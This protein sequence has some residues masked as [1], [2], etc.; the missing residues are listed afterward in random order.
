MKT[1][2]VAINNPNFRAGTQTDQ[3]EFVFSFMMEGAKTAALGDMICWLPAIKYIAENYDYV[4]GHLEVPAYFE[5]VARNVM[6]QYPH[7]RVH[8]VLPKRLRNGMPL[9][10]AHRHPINATGMH[11][12]D[13]GFIYYLGMMPPNESSRL[14]CELNLEDVEIWLDI[15]LRGELEKIEDTGAYVVLTPGASALTRAMPPSVF[16]SVVLHLLSKGITPVFL[17]NREMSE[18]V[19]GFDERYDLTKGLDLIGKTT[20]L[21]A[22]KIMR[23]AMFVM[24]I[25]NGL[26]H[27]AGMTDATI[28]YGYTMTGPNQRRIPRRHGHLVELF[29]DK[30]KIP[31]LFCQEHVRFFVDH[32]FTNCIYQENVPACVQALNAESWIA[33]IDQVIGEQDGTRD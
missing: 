33:T 18:R 1:K 27:L 10:Q 2:R 15:T 21:E 26:L 17:G 5:D 3:K 24:G 9:K 28:L 29:G 23:N 6:A 7:W 16:N 20:L 19:I 11:L 22:A 25:D 32:N 14:Y 4:L 31:C 8:S 13:L 12:V 30:E